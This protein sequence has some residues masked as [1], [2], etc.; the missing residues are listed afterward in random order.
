MLGCFGLA[1]KI[2]YIPVFERKIIAFGH[3][4]ML[5]VTPNISIF[6]TLEIY[7]CNVQ[8]QAVEDLRLS[9]G[10]CLRRWV[11]Q[12]DTICLA[13]IDIISSIFNDMS[14]LM[15]RR[16]RMTRLFFYVNSRGYITSGYLRSDAGAERDEFRDK[17]HR[18]RSSIGRLA[19]VNCLLSDERQTTSHTRKVSLTRILLLFVDNQLMILHAWF[20]GLR[21]RR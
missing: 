1:C 16:S 9:F 7:Y 8:W 6:S 11:M 5:R 13:S 12:F 3:L 19:T 20:F 10:E 15:K 2:R 4:S 17:S 21:E 18:Y 14:L